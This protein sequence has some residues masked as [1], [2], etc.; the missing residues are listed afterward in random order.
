VIQ[1][2]PKGSSAR[3]TSSATVVVRQSVSSAP[4]EVRGADVR[5]DRYRGHGA[6][7]QH[8][9]KVS[10]AIRLVHEPTGIM[11]TRESG[12]SQSANLESAMKQLH[13][14]LD[15]RGR[16]GQSARINEQRTVLFDDSSR[17]DF[18]H[19]EKRSEVVAHAS[20]KRY[21][22]GDWQSGKWTC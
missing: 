22:M 13:D 1:R 8:R 12:R 9:N 15:S 2:V 4:V 7:G 6:G 5:I 16:S 21:R 11:I 3:H 18:T 19:N 14:A 10:T 20:G 17:K